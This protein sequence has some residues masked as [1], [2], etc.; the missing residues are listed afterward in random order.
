PVT[1][2]QWTYSFGLDTGSS[3]SAFDTSMRSIVG[4]SL[5]EV[6]A[7]SPE[8]TTVNIYKTPRASLGR[9]QLQE[10]APAA[11]VDLSRFSSL[12]GYDISG[13]IGMD[14]LVGHVVQINFDQG[15]VYF[16]RSP[17]EDPGVA[18]PLIIEDEDN[19]VPA[20]EVTVANS[21]TERFQLDTGFYGF[22]YIRK[23]LCIGLARNK[24]LRIIGGGR[25]MT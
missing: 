15:R 22:G 2:Q 11:L 20:V 5:V 21:R 23:D 16:L 18:V 25:D 19:P 7:Q 6:T 8:N 13:Y 14:F 1:F 17:G 24:S 4:E 3:M 12:T 10:G 9:L